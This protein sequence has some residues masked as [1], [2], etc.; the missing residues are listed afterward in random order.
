MFFRK[1]TDHIPVNMS[2]NV[3]HL[4]GLCN[5]GMSRDSNKGRLDWSKIDQNLKNNYCSQTELLFN[6]I[7]VQV[8]AF[9]CKDPNCV[10]N[11]H[12]TELCNVYDSIV[13]CLCIA[14]ESLYQ[15]KNRVQ[16]IRPG[17]NEHVAEL[18][19]AAREA[20][21]IWVE[22]GKNRQGPLFEFKKR[23][24]ARF[25]YALRFIKNNENAMR[26][27][28]IAHKMQSNSYNDFWKEIK[29]VNN[30]KT[31]L[32]TNIEGTTGDAK[33]CELWRNHYKDL[34]NCVQSKMHDVANV[35]F[36]V[37]MVI[38]SE[39]VQEAVKQLDDNKS[40][41]LDTIS[42]EH[43]KFASLKLMPLLAMCISGFLIHGILPDSMISVV[44]VPVIKNK[45][46]RIASKDNYRP[47][48]L[49][50][51]LSKVLEKILLSRLEMYILTKDNQFGFKAKHGT[52]MCIFALKEIIARYHSRHSSMFLC[53]L[54]ASKAFDR[55]NH[56][57]LFKKMAD[58][59]IPLYLIRILVFWYAHQTMMV[60]W[61]SSM[62][63]KKILSQTR[64]YSFSFPF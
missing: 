57:K 55:I 21:L 19:S 18:H 4:P 23:A 13:E 39:E 24:N 53:F 58:R 11:A 7:N 45:A 25:K 3:D 41:G 34:F 10:N 33:I 20:H 32:P 17:W 26:A 22:A 43:L 1:T 63:V 37:N 50:S 8:D 28:S 48:A 59:G 16:N 64:G 52:D 9:L 40:C 46:G 38:T 54:D 56:G 36:D 42:A 15:C 49:A 31:P 62:S 27:D 5:I 6:D 60:R 14:S 61:G 29:F 44:L 12:A 30:S 47:I 35:D 2:I 51:V